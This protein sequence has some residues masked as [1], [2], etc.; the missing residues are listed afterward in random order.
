M[1]RRTEYTVD[2]QPKLLLIAI[3]AEDLVEPVVKA[4][5][6]AARSDKIRAGKIFVTSLDDVIRIR[7]AE[8]GR[9]AI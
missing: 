3:I 6:D 5:A 4:I 7:T 8:R 9:D 1:Y 2:F